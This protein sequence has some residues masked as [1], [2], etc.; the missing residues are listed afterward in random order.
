MFSL[1]CGSKPA[2]YSDSATSDDDHSG[3]HHHSGSSD[4]YFDD[5]FGDIDTIASEDIVSDIDS[6]SSN[7]QSN[8]SPARSSFSGSSRSSVDIVWDI[9]ADSSATSSENGSAVSNSSSAS[10]ST[11]TLQSDSSSSRSSSSADSYK[12]HSRNDNQRYGIDIERQMLLT[13]DDILFFG[14]SYA[15]FAEP[16]QGVRNSLNIDRFKAHFGPEPRTVKDILLDLKAEFGGGIVFKDVMMAMNWLK[17]C[18]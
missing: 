15:G 1:H 4:E 10:A 17:L 6:E 7:T 5:S 12:S 16:R 11:S 9:D 8:G 13:E 18:K 14:L 2:E 3:S